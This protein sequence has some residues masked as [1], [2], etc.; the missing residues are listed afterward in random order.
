MGHRTRKEQG[1]S[2][3]IH[4]QISWYGNTTYLTTEIRRRFL[5]FSA[6]PTSFMKYT[7]HIIFNFLAL[8]FL[9][10]LY[11]INPFLTTT[12]LF[13]LLVSYFI[14]TVL[15]SPDLD[16]VSFPSNK[17]GLLAYPYRKLFTHRKVSHHWLYGIITRIIYFILIFLIIFIVLF[18]AKPLPEIL[19]LLINYKL[20]ILSATAGLFLSNLFHIIADSIT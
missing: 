19:T 15:L 17:I 8:I 1:L 7:G 4:I 9:I 11:Q 3:S 13:V 5:N 18:G 6:S 14:G 16:T 20:E 10:I 12:Q 2:T